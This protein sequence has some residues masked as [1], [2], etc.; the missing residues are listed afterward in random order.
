MTWIA[1]LRHWTLHHMLGWFARRLF[2]L[3]SWGWER[4]PKTG[5]VLLAP[6]HLG[7]LDCLLIVA[8]CP[9]PVRFL[10]AESMLRYGW[11]RPVYRFCGVIPTDPSRAR[12]VLRDA[13]T[14]LAAGEV[15][16][17]FPEGQ[18]S[19]DGQLQSLQRGIEVLARRHASPVLPVQLRY[20]P[21]QRWPRR[22]RRRAAQMPLL[23]HPGHAHIAVQPPLHP[24]ELTLP[25]LAAR[26]QPREPVL[27]TSS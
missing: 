1:R 14:A 15:L 8:T 4:L 11:L 10:G 12:Q 27:S 19:R 23:R 22:W 6:N 20:Q 16:C 18:I 21:G 26:L 3:R 9:R 24:A 7:Y 25:T 13:G 2:F 17:L 5:P